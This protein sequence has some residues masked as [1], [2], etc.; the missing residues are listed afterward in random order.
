MSKFIQKQ[1]RRLKNC[2][3]LAGVVRKI[4]YKID[5]KNAMKQFGTASFP[6][7]EERIMQSKT[8]FKKN[9]KFSILVPLY[10]TP[11]NYLVDMIESVRNQTYQNWELCLADGSD[12]EHEYVWNTP[13]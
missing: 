11:E 3:S 4:K 12:R 5:E 9:T 13:I 8:V 10:N 7:E 6:S 2:G 1:V